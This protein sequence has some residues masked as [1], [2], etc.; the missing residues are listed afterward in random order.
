MEDNE[1]LNN[2]KTVLKDPVIC[3]GSQIIGETD[4]F[5]IFFKQLIVL[6]YG[7]VKDKSVKYEG[8]WYLIVINLNFI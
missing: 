1:Y 3:N 7:F 2:L 8:N 4:N 6:G 5:E